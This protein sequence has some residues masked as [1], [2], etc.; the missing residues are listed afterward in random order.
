MSEI[1]NDIQE[2]YRKAG[3][4][5]AD[6]L[7]LGQKL[8]KP[9]VPII[10]ICERTE[11]VIRDHGVELAF[12]TN[13]SLDD[14]AAHYSSPLDDNLVLPESGLLKI[15]CGAHC[16]GFIADA[17]RTVNLGNDGGIH[18]TLCNAAERALECAIESFK[19]GVPLYEIGE[20]IN[21]EITKLG[22]RPISNLGGHQ[23]RQHR[24]HGEY[25]PNVMDPTCK[26]KIQVGDAFALEPFSTDGFG[27]V[28]NGDGTYIYRYLKSFSKKARGVK[29][30]DK[31]LLATFKG[32][33]GSLPFSPRWVDFVER[34]EVNQLIERFTGKGVLESYKVLVEKNG[35][36]VAQWENTVI[37]HDDGA[38]V[39]TR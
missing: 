4:A 29:Q 18:E 7:D 37:V 25:V 10:E 30:R 39:T 38:E 36:L 33:F 34:G 1:P 35:G 20:V 19:P 11:R 9:G 32:R 17:A 14:I 24:L 27:K 5:V 3:K 26:Y 12:P 23:L 6:A 15:D 16:D 8:A 13:A 31:R 28:K 22:V 2:K 21:G